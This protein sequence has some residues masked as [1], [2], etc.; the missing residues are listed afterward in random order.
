M[1]YGELK[2][3]FEGLLKRRD[4]TSTQRDTW[5]Q[6]AISRAQ[7]K[8]RV[9]AMEQSVT[10]TT[11]SAEQDGFISI[12]NDLIELKAISI[13][14]EETDMQSRPLREVLKSRT[15]TGIPTMYVRRNSTYVFGQYPQDGLVVRIDYWAELDVLSEDEDTNWLSE[16]APDVIVYGALSYAA[17]WFLDKRAPM[18]EARF[19]QGLQELQD[20]ADRDELTNAVVAPS[21]I[22]PDAE[23]Y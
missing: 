21:H 6:M 11:D 16:I 22:Y 8:L 4:L 19:N 23:W 13:D 12:P 15:T 5:L 1:N 9:P 2:T 18:F 10:F 17:D 7:R 3:Q 20:Q 14:A